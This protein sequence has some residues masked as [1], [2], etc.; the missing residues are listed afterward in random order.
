VDISD[1]GEFGFIDR[2]R[3]WVGPGS[4]P[5]GIGDDAAVV[6]LRPSASLVA[7]ADALVEDVHFRWSWSSPA[8]VGWKSVVVN[9]SDLAAMGAEPRWMLVTLGAPPDTSEERL[10]ALYGGV[11]EACR[12]YGCEL[13]GGDTVRTPT[14][15]IAVT[16]LG[17]IHGEPLR[18]SG[19][20][21]GDVLAVTG[22]LGKAAAGLNLLMSGDP[23]KGPPSDALR[24]IDAHRRPAARVAEGGALQRAAAH[25]AMDVSDGLASDVR[26]LAEASGVGIEI[27]SV[28]VAP[29][30]QRIADARG[31]DARAMALGGGEDMELLAALPTEQVDVAGCELIPIGRVVEEGLWLLRDGERIPL[32]DAG[33]DHFRSAAP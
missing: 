18:R 8:D 32:P 13:V 30:A 28:P 29:E 19:A 17:E 14:V 26:R 24:C 11:D 31:W 12:E 4:A 1:L 5:V 21:P 22:P 15:V 16:A 3:S 23:T 7:T 2:V 25:A 10:K 6:N 33:F 27:E 9:V 20:E